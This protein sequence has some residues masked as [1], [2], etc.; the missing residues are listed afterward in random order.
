MNGR[1]FGGQL[2]RRRQP[3]LHDGEITRR[4]V[5]VEIVHVAA[6]L[7]AFLHRAGSPGRSAARQRRPSERRHSLFRLRKGRDHPTE[8]VAADAGAADGD[9]A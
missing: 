1:L 3:A 4:E 7:E 2:H 5:A 8:Q 6:N 9:Q